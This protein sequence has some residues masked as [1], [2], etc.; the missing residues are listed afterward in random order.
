M[1]TSGVRTDR[2]LA[3]FSLPPQL[4]GPLFGKKTESSGEIRPMNLRIDRDSA[5]YGHENLMKRIVSG[6][7]VLLLSLNVVFGVL[8]QGV[9]CLHGGFD[10]HFEASAIESWSCQKSD[11]KETVLS[12]PEDACPPCTDVV[13]RASD[14]VS[15]RGF[16]RL[17]P[18]A[19]V[20]AILSIT[21][22]E[23]EILVPEGRIVSV[24]AP[25]A[26]PFTESLSL[27]VARTQ[28]L[29]I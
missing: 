17:L 11:T 15:M 19:P 10:A 25:R 23:L 21:G 1:E 8:G 14:V 7:L 5:V 6:M 29:R 4:F 9:L 2:G 27:M 24:A 13:I 3:R 26:P 28:V 22:S 16:D 18:T 12:V 20:P